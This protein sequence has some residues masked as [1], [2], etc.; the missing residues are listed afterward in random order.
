MNAGGV[1]RTG[2]LQVKFADESSLQELYTQT[3]AAC[4]HEKSARNQK[5]EQ[6]AYRKPERCFG[7]DLKSSICLARHVQSLTPKKNLYFRS[8]M[9][10][11]QLSEFL[12]SCNEAENPESRG[13]RA[14]E[15]GIWR[16]RWSLSCP[17]QEAP[18]A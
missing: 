8:V 5:V 17:S 15:H 14:L 1:I 11:R 12:D 3:L 18:K 10:I 2:P 6:A 9:T 4:L 13:W 7:P 16:E